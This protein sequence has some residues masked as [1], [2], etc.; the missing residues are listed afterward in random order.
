MQDNIAQTDENIASLV[1]MGD[2]DAFGILI[3]R[4]QG[5]IMRYGNKFLSRY[6]DRQDSVQDVFLRAYEN[7]QSFN[8]KQRF[9]PWIYR[10][11]H[12]IFVNVI[13][14][15]GREK[16]SFFEPDSFFA[17]SLP[18]DSK[19]QYEFSQ[20]GNDMDKALSLLSPKYREPIVLYYF[21]QKDY[22]EIAEI[23]HISISTVGVRISR[24]KKQL[25]KYH[26]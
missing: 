22:K 5:K 17:K 18:D 11:A 12:N 7:I 13:K 4:Y 21:E 26:E 6:E 19:D 24:A 1:Q 2:I 15:H 3:N 20:L 16:L 25:K 10:I 8:T 14:K 9:S 23:L